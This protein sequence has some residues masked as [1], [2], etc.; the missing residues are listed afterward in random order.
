MIFEIVIYETDSEGRRVVEH[1]HTSL[2]TPSDLRNTADTLNANSID[3]A[4]TTFADEIESIL[5]AL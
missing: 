1:G 2:L 4:V 5:E 3:G